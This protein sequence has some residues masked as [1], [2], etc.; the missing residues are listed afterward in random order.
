MPSL[1]IVVALAEDRVIGR[2]NKLP[3][4]IPRDLHN[5]R[6][7]TLGKPIIMGRKTFESIGQP[8]AK[9]TNIVVTRDGA[10]ARPGIQVARDLDE[11]IDMARR[12]S[13][14]F[15]DGEIMVIG[16]EQIFELAL[17]EAQRMYM[18]TVH[19]RVPDGDAKFPLFDRSAWK[20]RE[21]EI[22]HVDHSTPVECRYEILARI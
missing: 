13:G 12:A 3:W 14:V 2:G 1:S 10:F 11:A 6:D 9:R 19:T 15:S 18:T 4:H 22:W 21:S 8:L 20:V 16:G 5:F 17:D 7:V